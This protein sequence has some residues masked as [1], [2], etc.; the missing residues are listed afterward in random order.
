MSQPYQPHPSGPAAGWQPQPGPYLPPP[1][2]TSTRGARI[3]TLLGVLALVV[4]V[5]VGVVGIRTLSDAVTDPLRPS[6]GSIVIARGPSD[7]PLTLEAEAGRTYSLVALD[8]TSA[9]SVAATASVAG[10]DGAPVRV[11]P[12][13]ESTHLS[14]DGYTV[15]R[16][17]SFTT[18]TAGT[19]T[20]DV[21]SSVARS[22]DVAVADPGAVDDLAR[23][24]V[25]G[26]VLVVA[27]V[28]G[29]GIGLVLS[30]S[31]WIWWAVRRSN[32]R[33][34]AAV[35]SGAYGYPPQRY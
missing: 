25:V 3:L 19:Y 34:V 17:A 31:G 14:V 28:I 9:A 33:K 10:P 4:A 35:Q 2:K 1:P 13:D 15:S 24:L 21:V 27:G 7:A 32:Q 20:I 6:A 30:I 16:F 22:W 18:T 23:D 11:V 5:V 26:V 8:R 29:A 12:V